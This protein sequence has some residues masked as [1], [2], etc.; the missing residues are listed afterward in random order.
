MKGFKQLFG[1]LFVILPQLC[2]GIDV[3]ANCI[4]KNSDGECFNESSGFL[5]SIE[6]HVMLPELL[7]QKIH[8]NK[9][10][11]V[12]SSASS[13]PM[14][15]F[16]NRYDETSKYNMH[17]HNIVMHKEAMQQQI[18]RLINIKQLKYDSPNRKDYIYGFN[19]SIP[20]DSK[21]TNYR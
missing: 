13:K 16:I 4:I 7:D 2:I 9:S 11:V 19:F 1:V 12:S 5:L 15:V 8:K 18:N 21:N 10:Y 20:L 3:S 17:Q 6:S 14:S